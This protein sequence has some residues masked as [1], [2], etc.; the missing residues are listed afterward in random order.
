MKFPV[1]KQ[2]VLLILV[3]VCLVSVTVAAVGREPLSLQKTRR[4]LEVTHREYLQT[5]EACGP[6]TP[7][8]LRAF[9][10]YMLA[11]QDHARHKKV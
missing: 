6:G 3:S 2:G 8:T 5:I 7:E 4:Y 10:R 9:D 11:Y 1:G